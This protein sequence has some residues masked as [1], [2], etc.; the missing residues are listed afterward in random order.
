RA[1]VAG[2]PRG[3]AVAF[4]FD[5]RGRGI[6]HAAGV[7]EAGAGACV[8]VVDRLVPTCQTSTWASSGCA[9]T[10]STREYACVG[11]PCPGVSVAKAEMFPVVVYW[12][13]LRNLPPVE[14]ERG[15][16]QR[17][18]PAALHEWAITLAH[19]YHPEVFVHPLPG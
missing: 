10:S 18:T 11:G 2:P 16:T 6:G 15:P 3:G 14:A 9:G 19:Q 13:S 17:Q 7:R 4:L 1:G 8:E 5:A 12:K